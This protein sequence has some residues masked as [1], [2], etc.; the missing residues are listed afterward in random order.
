MAALA[1]DIAVPDCLMGKKLSS[2]NLWMCLRCVWT[3]KG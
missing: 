3:R 2:T 1:A